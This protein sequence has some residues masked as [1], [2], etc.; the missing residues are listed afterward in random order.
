MLKDS[1]M[2]NLGYRGLQH[3]ERLGC[4][5]MR[6]LRHLLAGQVPMQRNAILINKM[7]FEDRTLYACGDDINEYWLML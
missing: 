6:M 1:C 2:M 7:D 3:D 5:V 4:T